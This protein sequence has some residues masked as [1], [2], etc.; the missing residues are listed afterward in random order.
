MQ[1]PSCWK[2]TPEQQALLRDVVRHKDVADLGSGSGTLARL[3]AR[4]GAKSV[5]AVDK[6]YT[7][8]RIPKPANRK[9]RFVGALFADLEQLPPDTVA[10]MSWP[11][12]YEFVSRRLLWVTHNVHTVVYIGIND[13]VTQCGTPT[14]FAGLEERLGSPLKKGGYQDMLVYSRSIVRSPV[15]KEKT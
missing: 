6:E 8:G 12:N 13:G 1:L 3:C 15:A 9:I 4:L 7:N 5:L 2:I 11:V 14:L 10:V